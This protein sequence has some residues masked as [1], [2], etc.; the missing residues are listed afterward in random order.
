MYRGRAL[1]G[2]P[3]GLWYTEGMD[4]KE[5][6]DN[7]IAL[8]KRLADGELD[9][10]SF[11]TLP[12]ELRHAFHELWSVNSKLGHDHVEIEHCGGCRCGGCNGRC[13]GAGGYGVR[14]G[15]GKRK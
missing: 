10:Y 8:L 5:L 11:K 15:N 12:D 4:T 13:A 9:S 1:T 2:V 14:V 6:S 7:Q 3:F